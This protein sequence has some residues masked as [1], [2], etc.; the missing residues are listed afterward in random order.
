[1]CKHKKIKKKKQEQKKIWSKAKHVMKS[2]SYFQYIWVNEDQVLQHNA[3]LCIVY[4]W[5]M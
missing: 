1:M 5:K 3:Q 4:E 2:D